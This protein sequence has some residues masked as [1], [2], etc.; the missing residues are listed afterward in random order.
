[1]I[2]RCQILFI[3]LF[4][5]SALASFAQTDGKPYKDW[6]ELAEKGDA[7]AQAMVAYHHKEGIEVD[8]DLNKATEWALKASA[9][10]DG[11]AYWLLA[12]M[13]IGRKGKRENLD[14]ALS[15]NYPLVAPLYAR[16]YYFGS[17]YFNIR[18]NKF[19]IQ[20]SDYEIG[21]NKLNAREN[22]RINDKA[23]EFFH[24]AANNGFS[25]D[26][27]FLGNYYLKEIKDTIKAFDYFHLAAKRGD[28]ESMTMTAYM[29]HYGCG[30]KKDDAAAFEWYRKA[31]AGGAQSGIEGLADCYRMGIGVPVNL[32]EAFKYYL[33]IEKPSLRV[34]YI[35]S[36]YYAKSNGGEEDLRKAKSLLYYSEILGYLYSQ[37]IIG[38]SR[39]EGVSPFEKDVEQAL[40]YLLSA[41]S[42][43]SFGDLPP[44]IQHKVCKYLSGYYRFARYVEEDVQLAEQLFEKAE[45]LQAEI[46]NTV[47]P[48]AFVGMMP[49]DDVFSNYSPKLSPASMVLKQVVFD[50]PSGT[51]V[52]KQN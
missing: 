39:Y 48:Y 11:L 35:L 50:Y 13:H 23:I 47:S 51:E 9:A 10:H 32:E 40:P 16:L 14:A 24:R 3:V 52:I 15:C 5:S 20:V 30:T 43:E 29:L 22:K 2:F 28:L 49:I 7:H 36:F 38:I 19:S 12:Q 45:S 1:M 26:S 4:L 25:E 17:E 42:D 44:L 37:A 21:L 8:K 34:L 46:D 41:Y 27:A 6:L 33:Q 18:Q 31:A